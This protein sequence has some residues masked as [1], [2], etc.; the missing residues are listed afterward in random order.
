[1]S[2]LRRRRR[3]GGP[4]VGLTREA[5]LRAAGAFDVNELSMPALAA[6]LG[7]STAAL[8]HHVPGKSALVRALAE[9]A[10]RDV[11]LRDSGSRDWR[12]L[13]AE[14]AHAMLDVLLERWASLPHIGASI[15]AAAE[16]VAERILFALEA[17]GCDEQRAAATLE[18]IFAWC[19]YSA[20][21]TAY[22]AEHGLDTR[23]ALGAYWDATGSARDSRTRVLVD[24]YAGK[25]RRELFDATLGVILDGVSV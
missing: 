6:S 16:P 20:M 11:H 1:M 2:T 5:I 4:P 15:G 19:V 13:I 25:S 10:L 9:Q 14:A 22:L 3:P 17:A 18:Q 12:D 7:V 8:Y 24:R 23:A 21:Q